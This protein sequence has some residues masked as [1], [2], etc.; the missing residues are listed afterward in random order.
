MNNRALD[1]VLHTAQSVKISVSG[2]SWYDLWHVHPDADGAGNEGADARRACLEALRVAYEHIL[3]QLG[4]LRTP[5]QSWV[6]IDPADSGQ[7]A[8]YVHTPN[9]NRQN[10]PYQF[11]DVDWSFAV[12]DWINETFPANVYR[13]GRSNYQGNVMYWALRKEPS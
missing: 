6:L 8:V 5:H 1:A 9:P 7:D 13:L 12:P 3:G 11:D 10:Y 2:A 4:S